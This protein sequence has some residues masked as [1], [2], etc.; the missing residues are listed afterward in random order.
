[1][2]HYDN[3]FIPVLQRLPEK[4]REKDEKLKEEMM[5]KK[6]IRFVMVLFSIMVYLFIFPINKA[7]WMKNVKSYFLTSFI[8]S[9]LYL[10]IFKNLFVS[11]F[12]LFSYVQV[13]LFYIGVCFC[14]YIISI[15]LHIFSL[16]FVLISH[17]QYYRWIEK[18]W[19]HV[20]ETFWLVNKQF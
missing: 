6:N 2:E 15:Q 20:S 1:M 4:I 12:Y 7:V 3:D 18:A 9:M 14:C 11:M 17:L 10:A 5:G 19:E 8:T 13:Y 16:H